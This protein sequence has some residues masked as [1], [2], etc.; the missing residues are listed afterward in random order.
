[1]ATRVSPRTQRDLVALG[2]N[3]ARWRK[4]QGLTAQLVADRAGVTRA[5]LRSIEHGDG[6]A[7]LENVFAVARVLGQAEAILAATDP[8]NSD[9]GRLHAAN[10]LPERVRVPRSPQVG[11]R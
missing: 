3:F 11:A 5:T 9:F 6:T 8:M 7:R 1:M 4:I 2:A 10:T